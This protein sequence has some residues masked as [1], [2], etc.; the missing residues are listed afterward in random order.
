MVLF[1]R[2]IVQDYFLWR[3]RAEKKLKRSRERKIKTNQLCKR[4]LYMHHIIMVWITL[5]FWCKT[6]L[7]LKNKQQTKILRRW[8]H[9]FKF[10]TVAF[11]IFVVF[12]FSCI[13][14]QGYDTIKLSYHL[15][16]FKIN[17]SLSDKTTTT[18]NYIQF[19]AL[20]YLKLKS[21]LSS[22]ICLI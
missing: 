13:D 14:C 19:Q 20:V 17:L 2:L 21:A 10:R 3:K 1:F 5:L 22:L 15:S 8:I 11:S 12:F 16:A 6:M 18:K 4:K 7:F 9:F